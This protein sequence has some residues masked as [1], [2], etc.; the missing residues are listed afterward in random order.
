MS[1]HIATDPACL[2]STVQWARQHHKT[3][4]AF[5]KLPMGPGSQVGGESNQKRGN[6]AQCPDPVLSECTSLQEGESKTDN[7]CGFGHKGE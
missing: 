4:M 1:E 6:Q 2:A 3:N 7:L 5:D